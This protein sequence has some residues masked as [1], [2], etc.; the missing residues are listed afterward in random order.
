MI[1]YYRYL[2][3]EDESVQLFRVAFCRSDFLQNPYFSLLLLFNQEKTNTR[4][5]AQYS[6]AQCKEESVKFQF[7]KIQFK[8]ITFIITIK[9]LSYKANCN[10]PHKSEII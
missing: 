8:K 7:L 4:C 2:F 6:G 9:N 10:L 1:Y 3:C 5:F